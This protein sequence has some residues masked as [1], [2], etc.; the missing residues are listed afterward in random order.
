M[1]E[2]H[3][4]G[5][6]SVTVLALS[7]RLT[8]SSDAQTLLQKIKQLVGDGKTRVLLDLRGIA[9]IDSC[10]VGELVS[11]FTTLKKQGGLLKLVGPTSAVRDILRITRVA[12]LFEIFDAETEALASFPSTTETNPDSR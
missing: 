1:I 2:I 7:G 12:T 11:A 4:K 5:V 10:G 6:N 9:T 8:L 3:E